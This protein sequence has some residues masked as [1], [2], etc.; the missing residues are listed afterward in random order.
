MALNGSIP[1]KAGGGAMLTSV[2]GPP[3]SFNAGTPLLVDDRVATTDVVIAPGDGYAGLHYDAAGRLSIAVGGTPVN[4]VAGVPVDASGRVVGEVGTPVVYAPNGVPITASGRVAMQA[5]AGFDPAQLFAAGEVGGWWDPSDL[6]TLFQDAAGTIPVTATGQPVGRV[7]DKSGRGNHLTQ[8]TAAARPV[9][10]VAGALRYL[11]FDGVNDFLSANLDMSTT[12]ALTMWLGVTKLTDPAS[13]HQMQ[14]E[15][16]ANQGNNAGTFYF[17]DADTAPQYD[18]VSR[19]TALN[20]A[21]A[22]ATVATGVVTSVL[23]GQAKIS[24]DL[25]VMR[26]NGVQTGSTTGDQ[27]TGNYGNYPFYVGM[28]GGSQFPANIRVYGLIMRGAATIA[29]DVTAAEQWLAGKAGIAF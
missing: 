9:Y 20:F 28:R 3:V 27:G 22:S 7:N 2:T 16:S 17:N 13:S 19:G 26:R 12:D 23:T 8:A 15:F 18:F 11:V 21:V 6:T 29:A 1:K 24:T 14:V 10:T 25:N 5:A 4:W